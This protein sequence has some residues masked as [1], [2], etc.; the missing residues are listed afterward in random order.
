M[1]DRVPLRV[2]H[3]STSEHGGAG[4]AASRISGAINKIGHRSYLVTQDKSGSSALSLSGDNNRLLADQKIVRKFFGDFIQHKYLSRNRNVSVSNTLFSSSYPA[5]QVDECAP[6]MSSDIINLHWITQ[7]ISPDAVRRLLD[8]GKKVVWTLHDQWPFTG[9]CHYTAGCSKFQEVCSP[10]PQ[11]KLDPW[12]VPAV[13]Q[14]DKELCFSSPNLVVVCPSDWMADCARK[15]RVFRNNEIVT[16]RNPINH[17]IFSPLDSDDRFTMRSELGVGPTDLLVCFGATT[18]GEKRKGYG[19][20]RNAATA[21]HREMPSGS[22]LIVLTFGQNAEKIVELGPNHIDFGKLDSDAAIAMVLGVSDIVVIPSQED[23]YPNVMVEAMACGT[24]VGGF[25]VGGIPELVVDGQNGVLFSAPWSSESIAAGLLRFVSMREEWPSLR[26]HA[27]ASVYPS[28]SLTAIGRRYEQVYKSLLPLK[29]IVQA[30]VPLGGGKTSKSILTLFKQQTVAN[31]IILG[32][33]FAEN[34][35]EEHWRGVVSGY[36]KVDGE[37]AKPEEFISMF[38]TPWD[39]DFWNTRAGALNQATVF[40]SQHASGIAGVDIVAPAD[41]RGAIPLKEASLD[42]SPSATRSEAQK[43]SSD[44]SGVPLK[45]QLIEMFED[46]ENNYSHLSLGV[47]HESSGSAKFK[48]MHYG[49]AFGIEVREETFSGMSFAWPRGTPSDEWGPYLRIFESQA[50]ES[51]VDRLSAH[52]GQVPEAFR[53]VLQDLTK[54]VEMALL[55]ESSD[56]GRVNWR[57]AAVRLGTRRG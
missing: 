23:N 41:A 56:G 16:V 1:V 28:H 40:Q 49:G 32:P 11:L 35:I 52:I 38:T 17:E 48:L 54:I 9:G 44:W 39:G 31:E 29:R 53:M 3:I 36:A 12:D 51:F 46:L 57:E 37:I 25:A 7:M 24:P 33:V 14:C 13:L 18:G 5:I 4:R 34:L 21:V 19:Y 27:R 20:L 6:V 2:A 50:N 22:R 10:C 43:L 26:A 8:E 55:Q 45:V 15:S 42:R 30:S 47:G